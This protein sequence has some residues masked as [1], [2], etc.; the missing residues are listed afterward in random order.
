MAIVTAIIDAL[1]RFG[2]STQKSAIERQDEQLKD[3]NV[4]ER[5]RSIARSELGS[6]AQF[7]ATT[8]PV[9]EE[10]VS[11][12]DEELAPILENAALI[13]NFV[14]AFSTND[15]SELLL[16]QMDSAFGAWIE[17]DD[18]KGYTDDAVIEIAGA[19]FGK[20]CADNLN[21]RWIRV[22]DDLGSAIAVQGRVKEFR[23]FPYASIA[24]RIPK[25]EHGFF[26]AIFISLQDASERDWVPPG[27][28]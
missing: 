28:S 16:D 27:A 7:V 2:T 9:P 13:G 19:A 25:R 22:T 12:T 24:K 26:R 18:K 21:M 23:G 17:S 15:S 4:L 14:A 10:V 5:H 8:E 11:L 1:R 20:F 6:T 3:R